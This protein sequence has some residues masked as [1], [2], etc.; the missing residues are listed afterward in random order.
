MDTRGFTRRLLVIGV[1]T[2]AF[3]V[4]SVLV[5]GWTYEVINLPV[6]MVVIGMILESEVI[7]LPK[8]IRA[9]ITETRI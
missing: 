2:G 8:Q 4:T 1:Y 7:S 3:L 6:F 9:V 5:Q